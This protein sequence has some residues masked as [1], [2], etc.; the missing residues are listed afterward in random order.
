MSESCHI[1]SLDFSITS[2]VIYRG[3]LVSSSGTSIGPTKKEITS[4]SV[5][6]WKSCVWSCVYPLQPWFHPEDLILITW[7]ELSSSTYQVL[8]SKYTR[9]LL[10]VD[11]CQSF[12]ELDQSL[13]PRP[14]PPL[15]SS[16]TSSAPI[17]GSHLWHDCSSDD[18]MST[19][20]SSLVLLRP[21]PIAACAS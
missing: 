9:F 19:W 3:S 14:F 20:I 10:C 4:P 13:H 12:W 21:S 5:L 8:A 16:N 6:I 1:R 7:F 2:P 11:P 18:C 17:M 15:G